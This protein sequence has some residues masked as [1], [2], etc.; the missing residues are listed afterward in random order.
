MSRSDHGSGW[1]DTALARQALYRLASMALT[2]PRSGMW[3]QLSD[4]ATRET[5][6]AAAEVLRADP[7]A[8]AASLGRGESALETLDAAA[9]FDH[10][11][12]SAEE[13]EAAHAGIFG[14]VVSSA[15]CPSHETDYVSEKQI[16]QQ[17]H[18]LADVSGFYRAFG[19]APS[20]RFPERHDH[21][22]AELEFMASLVALERIAAES[23]EQERAD[24]CRDAER[25]FLEEH[26][27]WWAPTFARMLS[28]E[29][30][31][32]TFYGAVAAL[33]AALTPA[34]RG[35]LGVAVPKHGAQPAQSPG[36][37]ACDGCHG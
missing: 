11:A 27:A 21:I 12:G 3:A 22:S 36:S 24:L 18:A 9:V 28:L 17:S 5:A 34:E 16:F 7:D 23:G 10:L 14:L 26:L 8:R 32:N 2:D 35:L 4:P 29:A 6:I 37:D 1:G 15:A 20:R 19:L 30:G 13:Y 25:R 33:L 31:P